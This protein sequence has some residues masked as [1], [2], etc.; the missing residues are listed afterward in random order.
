M[1]MW[2]ILGVFSS[3]FLAF[4]EIFKKIALTGNSVI[5]VLF[6]GSVS[7][8]AVFVPFML[9]SHYLPGSPVNRI[10]HIPD[11][12]NEAHLFF[13]LKSV[14][15]ALA[16]LFSYFSVKHLPVTL[17]APV[18]A[19]GPV[20]TILGA[21]LIFDEKLTGLQWAGVIV[22]LGSYYLLSYGIREKEVHKN[23]SRW[24]FF[25][26]L[27]IL[28]NS[29]SALLDK[30]L[31]LHFDRL[32]MQA[33]FSI[34]TSAILLAVLLIIWYPS[35]KSSS[36]F[37]WKWAIVYI[38][39]F[40]VVADYLYF[41]A[42]SYENSLVS[43]LIMIRRASAVIVFTAGAVYFKETSLEKRIM[44]LAGI[45]AGVIMIIAGSK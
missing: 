39:L 44:M 28:F 6:A 26:F 20:W 22:S 37:I 19:S 7:G 12:G 29:L 31:V 43:I 18:N 1:I 4:H 9:I 15:V 38:G 35:R 34:Y 36:P 17:L 2:V 21:M 5:P 33:W 8:A 10:I 42:L 13:L 11:A 24:L 3:L 16:W 14:I 32:A 45:L 25:A 23:Y 41:K 27:G 40:L 30:Y